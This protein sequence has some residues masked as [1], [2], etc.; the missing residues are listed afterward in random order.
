MA[1]EKGWYLAAVGVLALSLSNWVMNQHG[2]WTSTMAQRGVALVQNASMALPSS[3]VRGPLP[4][5]R[6]FTIRT[7]EIPVAVVQARLS[8]RQAELARIQA[9]MARFQAEQARVMAEGSRL[10]RCRRAMMVRVP[11]PMLPDGGT[12]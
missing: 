1:T 5:V 11:T 8:C 10:P 2:N 12:I 6:V 4:P 3:A 7:P 9:E